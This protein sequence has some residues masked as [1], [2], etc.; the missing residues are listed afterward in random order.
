[1]LTEA[2]WT[3]RRR[4]DNG[5][6]HVLIP[7]AHVDTPQGLQAL[8]SLTLACLEALLPLLPQVT[9]DEGLAT[10]LTPPHERALARVFCV[11]GPDGQL[12]WGARMAAMDGIDIGDL[13]WGLLTPVHCAT[14]GGV[15]RMS[16]PETL[17][18]GA[19]ESNALFAAVK[20][21][22]T[23]QGLLM[24][25]GAPLRWY[26]AHESLA[27]LATASLDR[28]IGQDLQRWQPAPGP[29]IAAL[30]DQAYRLLEQHPVNLARLQ[31]GR[32]PVNALWLSSCGVGQP[33]R[34]RP[35]F[36]VL[37][38]LRGPA[39][40]EDWHAWREAW[41]ALD[42]GALRELLGRARRHERVRLTLA[43]SRSAVQ[44]DRQLLGR[45]SESPRRMSPA[46]VVELL[47][48]L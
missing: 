17:G 31:R 47:Q 21:L 35:R 32:Q 4:S 3:T 28:V 25:W 24:A 6:M 37:N 42:G 20:P 15:L 2:R 44:F 29:L 36:A 40:A 43:G 41:H 33:L 11:A 16:D 30:Q 9:R 23:E 38:D 14:E 39:F 22:F 10:S 34:S 8:G 19:S 45:G 7:F 27:G 5:G 48:S 13:A 18:L 26:L 1:M 12:P 46:Q